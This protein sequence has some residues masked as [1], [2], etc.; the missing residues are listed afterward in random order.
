M[1]YVLFCTVEGG[2]VLRTRARVRARASLLLL[3]LSAET[4]DRET[5]LGKI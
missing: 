2:G 5:Q 4:R 3:L 1:T